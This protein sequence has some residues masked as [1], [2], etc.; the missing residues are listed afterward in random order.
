MGVESEEDEETL[1][2]LSEV[3]AKETKEPEVPK[4]AVWQPKFKQRLAQVD[5]QAG[6]LEAEKQLRAV[7]NRVSE[8]N[9]DPMFAQLADIMEKGISGS[10]QRKDEYF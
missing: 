9:I 7:L 10:K 3:E 2:D 1:V 5:P 6:V 4:S 8:G